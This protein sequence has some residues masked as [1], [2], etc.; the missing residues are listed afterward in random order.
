MASDFAALLYGT[1]LQTSGRVVTDSGPFTLIL[2]EGMAPTAGMAI[3]LDQ[4]ILP[5]DL[6]DASD[7]DFAGYMASGRIR[8]FSQDQQGGNQQ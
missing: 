5:A 4:T 8:I 2:L 1:Y 7:P 3:W 6:N